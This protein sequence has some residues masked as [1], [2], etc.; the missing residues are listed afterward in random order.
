MASQ[1]GSFPTS[2]LF[3]FYNSGSLSPGFLLSGFYFPN[4]EP[5]FFRW[6]FFPSGDA[7][8]H[9]SPVILSTGKGVTKMR[10]LGW[11]AFNGRRRTYSLNNFTG[12]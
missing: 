7:K 8:K 2:A 6:D 4:H 10:E 1:L 9:F 3:F 5:T 11:Q 12:Q